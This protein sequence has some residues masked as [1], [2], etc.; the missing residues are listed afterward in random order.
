MVHGIARE[1]RPLIRA[2]KIQQPDVTTVMFV[3]ENSKASLVFNLMKTVGN[4]NVNAIVMEHGD[5]RKTEPF[6][7]AVGL[8][9]VENAMLGVTAIPRGKILFYHG[10][11]LTITAIV[12]VMVR[13]C[14]LHQMLK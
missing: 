14:V 2:G 13:G 4:L 11:V 6:I 10:V 3:G 8:M 7:L 9:A 12:T 1:D 5:V